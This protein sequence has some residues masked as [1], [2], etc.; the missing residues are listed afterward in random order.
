MGIEVRKVIFVFGMVQRFV[1]LVFVM[2]NFDRMIFY[3]LAKGVESD[4]QVH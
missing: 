3:R 1:M 2:G 4:Y